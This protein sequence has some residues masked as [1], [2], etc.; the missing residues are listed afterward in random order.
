MDDLKDLKKY[1]NK[2]YPNI[3]VALWCNDDKSHYSGI[4]RSSSESLSLNAS[5]MGEL[6]SQGEGFLRRYYV[7]RKT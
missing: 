5:T 4:M 1:W 7:A 3:Y 2:K 6:I